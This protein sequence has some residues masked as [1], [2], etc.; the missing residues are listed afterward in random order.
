MMGVFET[1]EPWHWL[2]LGF[3]LLSLEALGASGFLIGAAVAAFL[4]W[5]VTLV[6]PDLSWQHQLELYA[7]NA[8]VLTVLYWKF[9]RRFNQTTDAKNL[10]NRAAQ[11]IGRS[12]PVYKAIDHGVGKVK[13]GDALWKVK[14]DR[15]APVGAVVKVIASEGM[16]LKV[17]LETE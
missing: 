3:V 13:I 15:D 12:Y 8:L 6:F 14:A 16:T 4:Q 17:E 10:N 11:F 1:F 2:V 5:I 9:L 7:F